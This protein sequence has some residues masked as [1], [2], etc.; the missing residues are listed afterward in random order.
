MTEP[1]SNPYKL[2]TTCQHAIWD[3]EGC[4]CNRII[5]KMRKVCEA[6]TCERWELNQY[7]ETKEMN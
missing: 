3:K 6:E 1:V 5:S 4:Y 7:I 2:P